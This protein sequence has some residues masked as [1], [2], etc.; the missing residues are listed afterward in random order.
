MEPLGRIRN[1]R[2]SLWCF[3]SVNGTVKTSVV[4]LISHVSEQTEKALAYTE[5]GHV[6]YLEFEDYHWFENN[7][8]DSSKADDS[9][10]FQTKIWVSH[11]WG[12]I[13]LNWIGGHILALET[14]YK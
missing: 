5:C 4:S 1:N 10:S 7:F 9:F 8:D 2:L 11:V 12:T 13:K 6:Q 14:I 3:F